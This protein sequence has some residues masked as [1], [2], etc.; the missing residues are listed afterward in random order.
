MCTDE[1]GDKMCKTRRSNRNTEQTCNKCNLQRKNKRRIEK[2]T[3]SDKPSSPQALP[4][5]ADSGAHATLN[6]SPSRPT[7]STSDIMHLLLST[8]EDVAVYTAIVRELSRLFVAVLDRPC[9]S[10]GSV[11]GARICVRLAENR[12]RPSVSSDFQPAACHF[13]CREQLA[14]GRWTRSVSNCAKHSRQCAYI[15]QFTRRRLL[16]CP[17]NLCT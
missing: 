14:A 15:S 7:S 5:T 2:P 17:S 1:I 16:T 9:P 3:Y 8:L 13:G 12:S 6:N 4:G 11:R 10:T